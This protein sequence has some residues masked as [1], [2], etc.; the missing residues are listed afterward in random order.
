MSNK[1]QS[2]VVFR[3]YESGDEAEI[4]ELMKPYWKHFNSDRAQEFWRWEYTEGPNGQA[5]KMVAEHD[6]KIIGHYATLPMMMI[7]GEIMVKGG[8]AEGSVV[9]PLYRGNIAPKFCSQEKDVRIL[10]KLIENLFLAARKEGTDVIWGFPKEVAL[11][12]QVRAGYHYVPMP[13]NVLI[14]PIDASKAFSSV[15][16]QE[17][18]NKIFRSFLIYGAKIYYKLATT[19]VYFRKQKKQDN[20]QVNVQQISR[21][22]VDY[23][24]FWRR[25]VAGNKCITIKRDSKYMSWRFLDNPVRSHQVFV[26]KRNKEITAC[27]VT[28]IVKDRFSIG[29]VVD[30]LGLKEYEND[31]DLLLE[32]VISFLKNKGVISINT[33]FAK[34]RYSERYVE[35]LKRKKFLVLP[36]GSRLNLIVKILNSSLDRDFLLDLDNWYIT[37][38]FTE[39]V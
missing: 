22:D 4:I 1:E 5:F 12:P 25:Y 15:F 23:D 30:I 6:G 36:V 35:I 13:L 16:F 20:P 7:C 9:H 38:A 19:N 2:V 11:K 18:R 26:C 17:V 8:K 27:V 28:N 24:S 21:L 14:L 10:G 32:H 34:N 3:C 33:W 37:M 39:G 29:N 31:L